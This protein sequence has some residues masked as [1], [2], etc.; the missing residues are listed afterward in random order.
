[1]KLL[2]REQ[3]ELTKYLVQETDKV[4]ESHNNDPA[5]LVG[6]LLDIQDFIERHYIPQSVA[7]YIA[8]KLDIPSTRVF[9][10]ISFYSALHDKPRAKYP[11]EICDSVVCKVNDNESLEAMLVKILG[12]QIGQVTYDG[13]FIIEKVPCFGACDISPAIRINGKV[14]GNLK[15]EQDVQD[16]LST[17]V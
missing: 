2:S 14:F 8:K 17:L 12:I 9:D 16:I 1:M 4:L 7:E 10:V 11:I 15:T 3:N 13:R 5:Q 6:I